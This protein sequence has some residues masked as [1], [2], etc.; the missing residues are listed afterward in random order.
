MIFQMENNLT[1]MA[2]IMSGLF[3]LSREDI[4]NVKPHLPYWVSVSS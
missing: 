2:D 3:N 1:E 4:Y